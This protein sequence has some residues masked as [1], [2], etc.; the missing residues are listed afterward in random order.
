MTVTTL[1]RRLTVAEI[2]EQLRHPRR[3]PNWLEAFQH[4]QRRGWLFGPDLQTV[5]AFDMLTIAEA[6]GGWPAAPFACHGV[7]A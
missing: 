1:S 4:D 5:R 3:R 6:M 2:I 7:A